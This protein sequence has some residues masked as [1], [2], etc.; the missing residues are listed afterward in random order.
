MRNLSLQLGSNFLWVSVTFAHA[1]FFYGLMNSREDFWHG[2][3]WRKA[4]LLLFHILGCSV[5][6]SS[7]ILCSQVPSPERGGVPCESTSGATKSGLRHQRHSRPYVKQDPS[8]QHD[9]TVE[10]EWLPGRIR[11]RNSNFSNTETFHAS[12]PPQQLTLPLQKQHLGS[13]LLKS[14][15]LIRHHDLQ[16]DRAR[17]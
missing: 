15:F 10:R 11:E 13:I 6:F 7:P 1:Y 5:R 4:L 3:L 9:A 16:I 17:S 8:Y 14:Q 2:P 12:S